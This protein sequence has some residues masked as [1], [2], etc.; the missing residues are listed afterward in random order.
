MLNIPVSRRSHMAEPTVRITPFRAYEEVGTAPRTDVGC[1]TGVLAGL[2]SLHRP[3]SRSLPAHAVHFSAASNVRRLDET[4]YLARR[5]ALEDTMLNVVQNSGFRVEKKFGDHRCTVE[6]MH[7]DAQSLPSGD[8]HAVRIGGNIVKCDTGFNGKIFPCFNP[9]AILRGKASQSAL[10]RLGLGPVSA[11][12]LCRGKLHELPRR[13]GAKSDDRPLAI[14]S[15]Q[16]IQGEEIKIVR[17]AGAFR[18][19]LKRRDAR[20]MIAAAFVFGMTDVAKRERN[21]LHNIVREN[22]TGRLFLIDGCD[23]D[24]LEISLGMLPEKSIT[25][26]FGVSRQDLLQVLDDSVEEARAFAAANA[27]ALR[28]VDPYMASSRNA[29]A[30]LEVFEEYV[31][32]CKGRI[33]Q[34]RD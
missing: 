4:E 32:A 27:D 23:S 24:I 14:S 22:D 19:F 7:P 5:K 31:E 29:N 13:A 9:A 26:L 18:A 20:P 2:R 25:A 21:S 34:L 28:H 8:T 3:R 12:T 17:D 10:A 16:E 30:P 1:W 33:A 15:S 6:L 11:I